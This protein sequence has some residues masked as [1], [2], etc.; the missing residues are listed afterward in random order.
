MGDM[1]EVFRDMR[2]VNAARRSRNL[3]SADSVDDGNWIKHTN[4]HWSRKIG[5][6]RLDYWPSKNK[7]RIC[8]KTMHGDIGSFLHMHDPNYQGAEN[9]VHKKS[10]EEIWEEHG[11]KRVRNGVEDD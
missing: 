8:G 9:I 3:D 7:W 11:Y 10:N 2:S 1:G 4:Y 5:D 6:K